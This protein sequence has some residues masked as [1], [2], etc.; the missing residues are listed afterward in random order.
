MRNF[1]KPLLDCCFSS[2][3]SLL[4]DQNNFDQPLHVDCQSKKALSGVRSIYHNHYR[5]DV[6]N[7]FAKALRLTLSLNASGLGMR[8]NGTSLSS[9]SVLLTMWCSEWRVSITMAKR[10]DCGSLSVARLLAIKRRVVSCPSS[11][12]TGEDSLTIMLLLI[13]CLWVPSATMTTDKSKYHFMRCNM[14]IHVIIPSH[15][16]IVGGRCCSVNIRKTSKAKP[17][18]AN[19]FYM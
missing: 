19:N 17:S 15:A 14:R 11:S 3:C 7:S 8:I 18:C 10:I 5:I 16:E 4:R 6:F 1:R 9:S 13:R 12:I 2:Q